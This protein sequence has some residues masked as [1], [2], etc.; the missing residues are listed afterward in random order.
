M[1]SS[2]KWMIVS[3]VVLGFASGANAF[4]LNMNGSD[5]AAGW[6][7]NTVTVDYDP[8]CANIPAVQT[9]IAAAAGIW[10]GI[11][12]SDLSVSVGSQRSLSGAIT[13]YTGSGATQQYVGAPLI[14]CDSHFDSDFSLTSPSDI[15]GLELAP[16]LN[17]AGGSTFCPIQG[18]L[19]VLDADP[20]D[21]SDISNYDQAT[22]SI[23]VAHELGHALGFGHSA[24][25]NALMYYNATAKQEL[26]LAQD[27]ADAAAYLYPRNELGGAKVFG[28]GSVSEKGSSSG[29]DGGL[30]A[31]CCLLFAACFGI[32][33]FSKRRF[34]RR[35]SRS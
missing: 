5:I 7:S 2:K 25:V 28:C 3:W 20:S 22:V 32:I 16:I 1:A 31:E 18:G 24:D 29:G 14:Y 4:T 13:T 33:S 23:V 21:L 11:P 17:C 35:F 10:S 19:V 30:K 6:P 27:D 15:P 34:E 8:S 9:A 12:T 26:R